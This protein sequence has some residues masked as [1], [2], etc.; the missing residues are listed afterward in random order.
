MILEDL[1]AMENHHKGWSNR[2]TFLVA[3]ELKTTPI[4]I[5]DILKES[6]GDIEV[7]SKMLRETMLT[8]FGLGVDGSNSVDK[9][10]LQFILD[11]VNWAEILQKQQYTF[12]REAQHKIWSTE[13]FTVNANSYEEA[14]ALFLKQCEEDAEPD[15]FEFIHDSADP[16]GLIEL[17]DEDRNQI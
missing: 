11:N 13:T 9:V 5:P 12:Y 10:A 6:S 8:H 17:F 2:E 3:E 7:A 16:T 14:K 1:Y 15:D 4:H